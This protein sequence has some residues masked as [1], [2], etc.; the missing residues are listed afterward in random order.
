M[1]VLWFYSMVLVLA[2]DCNPEI[3]NCESCDINNV[4]FY[5]KIDY[6]LDASKPLPCTPCH[7]TNCG[8]CD[9]TNHCLS[10]NEGNF[11]TE[12]GFCQICTNSSCSVCPNHICD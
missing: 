9:G 8:S 12:E 7:E 2:V 6:L 10:C 5:C 4:C 11:L 3:D 1:I